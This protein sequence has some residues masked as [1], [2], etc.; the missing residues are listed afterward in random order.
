MKYT[1]DTEQLQDL[2]E[3]IKGGTTAA[4]VLINV[5]KNLL[6]S[7]NIG[8]SR[9]FLYKQDGCKELLTQDHTTDTESELVRLEK[10][11][12]DRYEL[13]RNGRLGSHENTRSFGDYSLK[14]GYKYVDVLSWV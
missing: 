4:I 3:L 12:L 6:F 5:E 8:D 7:A 11:R 1:V 2:E 9:T 13:Q 14:R 10:L